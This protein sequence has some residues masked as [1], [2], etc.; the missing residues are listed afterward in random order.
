M[1]GDACLAPGVQRYALRAV[2]RGGN[3]LQRGRDDVGVDPD[4]EARLYLTDS[5][6][7]SLIELSSPPEA[8]SKLSLEKATVCTLASCPLSTASCVP[9]STPHS[10]TVLSNAPDANIAP[11]RD[12]AAQLR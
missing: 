12:S 7:Q 10:R 3:R 6:L 8:K 5:Q 1:S 9:A 2:H 11:F 4:T